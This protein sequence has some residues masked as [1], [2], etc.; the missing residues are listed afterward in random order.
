MNDLDF[1]TREFVYFGFLRKV[2]KSY[3]TKVQF[4]F[5]RVGMKTSLGGFFENSGLLSISYQTQGTEVE[6][7]IDA[8]IFYTVV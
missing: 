6:F 7:D 5:F 2:S 3:F 1:N 8:E 4:I